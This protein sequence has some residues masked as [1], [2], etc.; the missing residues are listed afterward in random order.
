M[1]S[2]SYLTIQDTLCFIFFNKYMATRGR[3][4]PFNSLQLVLYEKTCSM[5]FRNEQPTSVRNQCT[6]AAKAMVKKATDYNWQVLPWEAFDFI[7]D[8]TTKRAR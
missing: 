1:S 6:S 4:A 7:T 2:Q 5:K 3:E 8:L